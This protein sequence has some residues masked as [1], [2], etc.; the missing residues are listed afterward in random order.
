M[1][2]YL[3][4]HYRSFQNTIYNTPTLFY[5]CF[6]RNATDNKGHIQYTCSSDLDDLEKGVQYINPGTKTGIGKE[7]IGPKEFVDVAMKTLCEKLSIYNSE[8]A[9]VPATSKF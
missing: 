2:F 5:N 9:K 6:V 8:M 7:F 3:Q 1:C 4:K